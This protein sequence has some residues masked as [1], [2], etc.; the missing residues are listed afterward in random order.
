LQIRKLSGA[1]PR[2]GL[3]QQSRGNPLSAQKGLGINA[4]R[5]AVPEHSADKVH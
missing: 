5:D 4:G 3:A 1:D 2:L